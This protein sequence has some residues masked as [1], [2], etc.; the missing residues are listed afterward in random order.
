MSSLPKKSVFDKPEKE[1]ESGELL[2]MG[3]LELP[4]FFAKSQGGKR[5]VIKAFPVFAQTARF[6]RNF[7]KNNKPQYNCGFFVLFLR[8]TSH[9]HRQV[10]SR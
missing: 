4:F 9:T 7:G 3:D 6:G 5:P 2:V 8:G 10:L 1:N